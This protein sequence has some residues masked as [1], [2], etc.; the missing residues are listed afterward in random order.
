MAA[1]VAAAEVA[2]G[3]QVLKR[4]GGGGGARRWDEGRWDE[5]EAAG[6][7][8]SAYSTTVTVQERKKKPHSRFPSSLSGRRPSSKNINIYNVE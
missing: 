4:D 2:V 1:A 3:G 7:D 5:E 6:M 8:R